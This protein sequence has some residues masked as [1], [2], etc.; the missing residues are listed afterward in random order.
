MFIG[1]IHTYIFIA[2]EF[3]WNF[4]RFYWYP[5]PIFLIL[6]FKISKDFSRSVLNLA[7]VGDP[8]DNYI[9]A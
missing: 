4:T 7:T 3:K 6:D 2:H 5:S 9:C 8:L 1:S